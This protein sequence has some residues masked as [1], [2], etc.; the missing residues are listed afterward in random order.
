MSPNPVLAG[1]LA[2][3]LEDGARE[4]RAQRGDGQQAVAYAQRFGKHRAR[5]GLD[6]N[7]GRT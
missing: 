2:A 7:A 5:P 6:E 1:V 4:D 3:G